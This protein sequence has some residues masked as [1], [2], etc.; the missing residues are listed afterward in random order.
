MVKF[1]DYL[2]YYPRVEKIQRGMLGATIFI[3]KGEKGQFIVDPGVLGGN[4][5]KHYS[6]L[7][8]KD[9]IDIHETQAIFITHCHPDHMVAAHYWQTYI[10]NASGS[11]KVP[12]YVHPQGVRYLKDPDQLLQDLLKEAGWI[13][14]QISKLP[15]TLGDKMFSFLWTK[16]KPI[17]IISELLDNQVFDLGPILF[18]AEFTEG[19][20]LNHVAYRIIEKQSQKS[21]LLSGD[22]ISFKEIE[23]GKG[24][25][26]L[27]SVNTV[28]SDFS[29][30]L[31]SLKRILNNPPDIL[32]T[33]HYGI[34]HPKEEIIKRFKE[35]IELAET[36]KPRVLEYLKTGPKSFGKI[37]NHLIYFKHYL[38]G[39]ATRTS[40][41]YCV[42]RELMI[43]GLVEEIDK[44]KHIFALVG[45]KDV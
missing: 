28:I 16:P 37:N 38:S 17:E 42:L 45:A 12:V 36:Y 5:E 2:Y 11:G 35:A 21:I 3:V 40:T 44:K 34:Y 9:G 32:F 41:T 4:V 13:R 20:S 22:M 6:S 27:A 31:V 1:T 14:T 30:E 10:K 23:K 29:K 33:S 8:E 43:E 19:H 15:P 39:Y 26:A 25:R 18:R 7:M 24:I